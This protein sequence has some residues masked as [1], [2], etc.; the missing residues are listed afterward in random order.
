M[1]NEQQ[2][3]VSHLEFALAMR[4]AGLVTL[5]AALEDCTA[6]LAG[7]LAPEAWGIVCDGEVTVPDAKFW[8]DAR[9]AECGI[10]RDIEAINGRCF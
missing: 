10:R 3:I 9:A 1:T 8:S 5:A 6:K 7:A 4:K 2:V